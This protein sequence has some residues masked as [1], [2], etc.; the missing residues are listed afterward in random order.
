MKK[1][2]VILLVIG[3]GWVGVAYYFS[4]ESLKLIE[5]KQEVD[6]LNEVILENEMIADESAK[7]DLTYG[8]SIIYQSIDLTKPEYAV[9]NP[10]MQDFHASGKWD[11]LCL[12]EVLDVVVDDFGEEGFMNALIG[13]SIDYDNLALDPT[14]LRNLFSERPSLANALSLGFLNRYRNPG[15]LQQT[16]DRYKADLFKSIT[17]SLYQK[18]FEQQVDELLSAHEEISGQNNKEAFF[19]DLYFK[20]DTRNIHRQ[21]WK[22]TFW[23]RREIEKNDKVLYAILTEVKNHYN[24]Q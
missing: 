12:N 5:E 17:K 14:F 2:V 22:Y 16:F 15:N 23:K 10:C 7:E 8:N 21:Y 13:S 19:E 3:L 9:I 11:A 18:V 6:Y 1:A 24:E 20:A 4:S